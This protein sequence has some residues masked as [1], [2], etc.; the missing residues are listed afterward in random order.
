MTKLRVLD[1]SF[2]NLEDITSEPEAFRLPVN[3]SEVYLSN[4]QLEHLPWRHLR[5]VTQLNVLDVSGN[6]LKEFDQNLTELMVGNVTTVYNV[7]NPLQCDCFLRPL[8]RHMDRT[9]DLSN[10]YK[11]LQ[12]TGP[13]YLEG[14]FLFQL[15]EDRLN[16]PINVNTSLLLDNH[17]EMYDITPDL[18]FR[19]VTR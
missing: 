12:C 1:L 6:R 17:E 3:V 8:K 10:N 16:C 14:K 13:P 9:L 11:D 4:N 18:R 19:E 5:N 2:N 7:G 15:S